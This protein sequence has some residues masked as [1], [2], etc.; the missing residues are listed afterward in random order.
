MN[1]P[2][3]RR[4]GNRKTSEEAIAVFGGEVDGVRTQRK[5][6]TKQSSF[7]F[8]RPSFAHTVLLPGMTVFLLEHLPG[9]QGS[10][11]MPPIPK[12]P[13]RII[14]STA[15]YLSLSCGTH[16]IV[17]QLLIYLSGSLPNQ[18]HF[19]FSLVQ[20]LIVSGSK[21]RCYPNYHLI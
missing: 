9:F 18:E 4:F 15:P 21:V 11:P 19:D 5:S 17:L 6:W 1:R 12:F 10:V 2:Q 16:P 8:I 13:P 7:A 20:T 14:A 3:G